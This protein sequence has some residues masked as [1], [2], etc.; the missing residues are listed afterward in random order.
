MF[1]EITDGAGAFGPDAAEITFTGEKNGAQF[2]TVAVRRPSQR[3]RIAWREK[4]LDHVSVWHPTCGRNRGLPQWFH[5]QQTHAALSSGAPVLA[6]V[7]A[8]GTAHRTIALL[9]AVSDTALGYYVDDFPQTDE[10]V[11]FAELYRAEAGYTTV[12]RIDFSPLPL[13][14]ALGAVWRWWNEGHSPAAGRPAAAY[15]P[16]YSTWYNFHQR[17][18]QTALTREL[19]LAAELGFRTVILDDGWQIAGDGTKDYRKSGDWTPA[20]DKFPDFGRFVRDAHAFGQ[21]LILWFA[22]PFAG[23]ETAAYRRFREK[24]LFRQEGY[25]YAGT[26]DVRYKEVRAYLTETYLRFIR[27]YDI[28]GLKLDFIDTFRETPETPPHNDEMDARTVTEGVQMLL[29][30]LCAAALQIKPDFLFEFRQ[31][32]VG[33]DILRCANLLRVCDCAFDA[34]TN[35]LG[36]VDLRMMTRDLAI[37]SD[38]LLW[39]P[40]EAVENCALQLLNIL[41]AV[42][43]ISVRLT[44]ASDEQLR[45][46]RAHLSYRA[47]NRDLLLRGRLTVKHPELGYTAVR[48]ADEEAH[49][50]VAVL[51]AQNAWAVSCDNEDIWNATDEKEIAV[52]NPMGKKL[53]VTV[54]DC[55]CAPVRQFTAADA[56]F[57]VSTP[58]TGYVNLC[59]I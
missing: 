51:Y 49:R 54:Y 43:Q 22:V 21:K 45:L 39:S 20:P 48:A 53:R 9:D 35:R 4:M 8:D 46:L 11:F 27:E 10:V 26:L 32:Y 12:L 18:E 36:A 55:F 34:V 56:A 40:E 5:A 25:I 44:E 17:P 7:R 29:S 42:P 47:R 38:M 28:D 52:L 50:A 6:T 59:E 1:F 14:D 31:N 33:P 3:L 15:E 16:L 37:H 58:P 13:P 2:Y 24:L 57:A 30:E 41:F 23:F 19:R